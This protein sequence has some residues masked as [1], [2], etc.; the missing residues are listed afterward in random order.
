MGLS[1]YRKHQFTYCGVNQVLSGAHPC[2]HLCLCE[3]SDL[4]RD[5][6]PVSMTAV[7]L[8]ICKTQIL[9]VAFLSLLK[10]PVSSFFVVLGI[11]R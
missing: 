4:C 3:D 6:F 5:K 8:V 10:L 7:Y 11:G 9:G 1:N 2:V